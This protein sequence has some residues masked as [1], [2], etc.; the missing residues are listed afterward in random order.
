MG[1]NPNLGHIAFA[2]K[3]LRHLKHHGPFAD[4]GGSI[5]R[6]SISFL[7]R[8]LIPEIIPHAELSY[9]KSVGISAIQKVPNELTIREALAPKTDPF[10]R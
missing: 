9:A 2:S 4:R 6:A 1:T 3:S 10:L 7:A 5:F 8:P